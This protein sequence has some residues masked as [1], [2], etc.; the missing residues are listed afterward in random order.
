DPNADGVRNL[1]ASLEWVL[2]NKQ[3]DAMAVQKYDIRNE[4]GDF[5]ER[6]WSPLNTPVLG[7][8]GEVAFIIHRVEDVT[9]LVRLENQSAV[10]DKIARDQQHLIGELR[11]TVR[12]N[13]LLQAGRHYLASIVESSHDPIIATNLDGI[14]TS[15]NQAAEHLFGY[16]GNEIVGRPVSLIFPSFLQEEGSELLNR[17]AKGEHFTRFSTQRLAKN[18]AV[19][20][21]RLTLSPIRDSAGAIIGISKIV[22]DV[23]E[24]LLAE[25]RIRRLEADRGYLAD[26]VESSHDAIVA[27][28]MDGLIVSW[29]KAAERLFGYT[30]AEV[31]GMPVSMLLPPDLKRESDTM[32]EQ[33]SAGGNAIHYE[34]TRPHRDG[35]RVPVSITVSPVL[36]GKGNVK[37]VSSFLRDIT[38]Q[39]EA[40]ARLKHLQAELIHLSRWNTMGMM[41]STIAHE[42]NQPLTASVNYVRAA[43][44]ILSGPEPDILRAGSFLDKAVEENK[45]AGGII[46]SLRE[47]IDKRET[48]RAAENLNKVVEEAISLS[49]AGGPGSKTLVA[50]RLEPLLPPVMVDKIQIEQVLLNLIRNAMDAMEGKGEITITTAAETGFVRVSV[51]DDGPGIAPEVMKALFQPFITTKEKGMGIGL[52]ICQSIIEAHGGKVWAENGPQGGAI[53]HFRLPG[54]DTP[55]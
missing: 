2:K 19:L 37:G 5:E 28:N 34:S 47:F 3:S 55:S 45:L 44:R 22:E 4:S 26:I 6:H 9:E 43:R 51:A 23:T 16:P 42:L 24:K 50:V 15:W 13:A 40:E 11:R 10:Q 20:D 1:K 8:N 32:A 21:V 38:E 14:V 36:D 35:T 54:A 12:E 39:K 29:N 48:S 53:F 41:A 52:T 46:R 17:V 7:A 30:A 49:L 27:R 31:V 18:G 25:H 33:L